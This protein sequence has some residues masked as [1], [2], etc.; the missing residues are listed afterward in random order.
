MSRLA[1]WKLKDV[2][3]GFESVFQ[4]NTDLLLLE[5]IYVF[6]QTKFA[7]QLGQIRSLEQAVKAAAVAPRQRGDAVHVVTAAEIVLSWKKELHFISHITEAQDFLS[8]QHY[9]L[10]DGFINKVFKSLLVSKKTLSGVT[11]WTI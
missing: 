6:A 11:K 9:I 4:R 2:W 10:L 7:E 3:Y 8:Y 5:Y 1:I